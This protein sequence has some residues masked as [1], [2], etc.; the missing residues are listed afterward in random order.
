[1]V[2]DS[3]SVSSVAPPAPIRVVAAVVRRGDAY[4]VCQRPAHKRHGGLWE[5]PGG[6]VK[7]GES[8]A[9]AARREL[10]EELGVTVTATGVVRHTAPD[11][12]SAFVIEFLEVTIAGTPTPTEHAA[13]RWVAAAELPALPLA[14]GDRDFV[15]RRLL[16]PATVA[17]RPGRDG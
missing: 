8:L 17:G 12:G 2:L 4:L 14:P 3:L 7:D 16:A 6:K 9:A 1:V 15:E 5:F 11:P 10:A 13:V